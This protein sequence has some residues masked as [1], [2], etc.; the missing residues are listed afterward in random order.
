MAAARVPPR[1]KTT[2]EIPLPS[3]RKYVPGSG[4]PPPRISLAPPRDSTAYI[5]DQ[6]VLPADKDTTL[7]SRRVIHYHI[8]FADLPAVKLLIPCNKVLDYVSPREL[9][10]WEYNNLETKEEER[11]R[12]LAEKQR[13]G[14]PKKKPGRPP[15]VP[16]DDV[17]VSGL[18]AADETLLL[19]QEVAGPSLSTPQKR[20]MHRLLD[21][22][23]DNG[24]TSNVESDDAAI[25][26]QLHGEPE[27]AGMG[28]EG[29]LETDSESVDQLP[30]RYDS[31]GVDTPTRAGSMVPPSRSLISKSVAATP[32]KRGSSIGSPAA[33]PTLPPSNASTPGAGQIHPAWANAFGHSTR[34]EQPASSGFSGDLS[35][36]H[37]TPWSQ[38]AK[39]QQL[40]TSTSTARAAF[41]PHPGRDHKVADSRLSTPGS[42]TSSA[43][44][45]NTSASKRK[46]RPLNGN[47][48]VSQAQQQGMKRRKV[49]QEQMEEAPADEFEVKDLLDDQWFIENGVRVHKY[50][51]LWVGDWPEDQNPTW[52]PAA[53]IQNQ[54]LIDRYEKKKKAGFLK[55]VKKTQQTMHHYLVGRRYSSVAEAF[56]DGIHEQ[57]AAVVRDADTDTDPPNE[58]F[59]VTEN[60]G[61]IAANGTNPSLSFRA[62]DKLLARYKS[63]FPGV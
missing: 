3:V 42:V 29:D 39:A 63:S 33:Y 30:S 11:A 31:A 36:H 41:V 13:A 59:L 26:R 17:G 49:K 1:R 20:K 51:V 61:D 48:T 22:E 24:D 9:E 23:E 43:V 2:I 7:A 6:F 46:V 35:K 15:R 10:D 18:S 52:E 58:T 12:R 44:A 34:S 62:F 5:I 19:A 56:E 38:L 14:P 21:E 28:S 55:P 25:R 40:R 8:G 16:M 60:V 37:G 47:G 57:T 4:P 45:S 54:D 53:N 32:L 27:Y 50:L